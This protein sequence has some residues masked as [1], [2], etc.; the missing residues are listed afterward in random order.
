MGGRPRLSAHANQGGTAAGGATRVPLTAVA[1]VDQVR[2]LA[3]EAHDDAIGDRTVVSAVRNVDAVFDARLDVA[4]EVAAADAPRTATPFLDLVAVVVVALA[5]AVAAGVGRLLS[6][7]GADDPTAVAVTV[8]VSAVVGGAL[9]SWGVAAAARER[10]VLRAQRYASR[11]VVRAVLVAATAILAIAT[12]A[13]L[14]VRA[15]HEDVA[16]VQ[17]TALVASVALSALAL[18]VAVGA[19][20]EARRGASGGRLRRRPRGDAA[21]RARSEIASARDDARDQAAE[22][23]DRLPAEERQ[24]VEAAYRD[25]IARVTARAGFDPALAAALRS[26]EA[27]EAR[28]RIDSA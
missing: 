23:L 18:L 16:A 5:L 1:E 27:L 3:R 4:R 15:A 12:V 10:A 7:T 20:R 24:R 19:Y 21:A 28:Y 25:E 6:G 9:V 26:A 11:A 22:V 14:M 8:A 13:A 17:V 2:R